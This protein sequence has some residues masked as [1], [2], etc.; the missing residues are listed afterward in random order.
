MTDDD[1]DDDN[2]G[3]IIGMDDCQAKPNFLEKTCL[4]HSVHHTF[5]MT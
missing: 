1:D 3:V 4:C 2:Y 5:H